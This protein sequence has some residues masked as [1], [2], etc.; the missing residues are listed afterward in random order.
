LVMTV[1]LTAMP[2]TY[3]HPYTYMYTH[4]GSHMHHTC[5]HQACTT[6]AHALHTCMHYTRT[7]TCVHSCMC[8]PYITCKHALYIKTCTA[9]VCAH[10]LP[11]CPH[12]HAP[13]ALHTYAVT[14]LMQRYPMHTCIHIYTHHRHALH[15]PRTVCKH[16]LHPTLACTHTFTP[17][18]ALGLI[19]WAFL[20]QFLPPA[21]M[22]FI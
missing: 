20:S 10:A 4:V 19:A 6:H 15:M 17:S 5:K 12:T 1:S 18:A 3:R 14:L 2:S 21:E 16:T 7:C 13:Q 8:I 11:K 9:R 22:V